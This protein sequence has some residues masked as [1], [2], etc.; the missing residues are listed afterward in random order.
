MYIVNICFK[1]SVLIL[2]FH[3]LFR[4]FTASAL[5]LSLLCAGA[6]AYAAV[7][8]LKTNP[9]IRLDASSVA[10]KENGG[11][12]YLGVT[13]TPDA[14][15]APDVFSSNSTAATAVYTKKAETNIYI[16]FLVQRPGFLPF[17]F[18]MPGQREALR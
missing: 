5:A 18:G 9:A 4:K 6:P 13:V 8:S 14:G 16:P 12:Y 11:T 10:L 17:P 15:T 1:R 2:M 3:T 7:S